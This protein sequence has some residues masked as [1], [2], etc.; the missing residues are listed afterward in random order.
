MAHPNLSPNPYP[1]LNPNPNPNP[2]LDPSPSPNLTLTITITLQEKKRL[3]DAHMNI[4][5]E[6]LRHIKVSIPIVS[7]PIVRAAAA[8]QGARPRLY[9]LL[10]AGCLLLAAH[11]A[12]L[13]AHY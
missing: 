6:L 4:A 9:K 11:C 13:T 10:A 7:I 2:N 3:I 1:N 5:T 8:D 12:L